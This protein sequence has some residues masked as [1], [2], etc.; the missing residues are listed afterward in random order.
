MAML[1]NVFNASEVSKGFDPIPENWYEAQITKSELKESK[2]GGKFLALT[3]KVINGDFAGR[4]VFTNLNLVHKDTAVVNRAQADL[5]RICEA[6][7][8]E[9]IEDS[10]ELHG[11]PIGI[12]VV[13]T[14][15]DAKWPDRNDIRG[16]SSLEKLPD[17]NPF[18]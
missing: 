13:I 8:L 10:T 2:T 1:P 3:F 6:C 7:D 16:Y 17:D 12:R 14:P 15:G 5:A 9:T 11:I 4:L 18:S